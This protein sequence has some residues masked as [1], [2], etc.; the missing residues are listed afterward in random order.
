MYDYLEVNN[1]GA[2]NFYKYW[3]KHIGNKFYFRLLN[4][5]F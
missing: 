2:L 3:N 4:D 1:L 5:I